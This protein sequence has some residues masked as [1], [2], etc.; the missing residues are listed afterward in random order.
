MALQLSTALAS[1]TNLKKDIS[2]V[3]SATFIEW[4]D[5]L[6]K[7]A[8]RALVATDT[9][10]FIKSY[11]LN[12]ASGNQTYALPVD[13]RSMDEFNCGLYYVDQTGKQTEQRLAHT[14]F[15]SQI[16]GFYLDH[17]N[18]MITPQP[19]QPVVYT[20][21]YI[22]VQV[23]LATVTDYF[24]T[25]TTLT[26]IEIIPDEYLQYVVYALDALYNVWD[27]EPGAESFAD[28]R[29]T[30]ALDELIRNIRKE[31]AAYSFPDYSV[32]F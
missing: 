23:K 20:L 4:C 25:D 29:F 15:G 27:E 11:T 1:L 21:R 19:Q 12:V 18:I 17:G 28:A 2:D 7:F 5:Y 3:P 30:R 24:T 26:G 6:N 32:T 9:Q 22:P 10:R 14:G 13:F 16:L 31:G 8:Y